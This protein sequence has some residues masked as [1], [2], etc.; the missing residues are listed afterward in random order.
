MLYSNAEAVLRGGEIVELPAIWP[1]IPPESSERVPFS[2]VKVHRDDTETQSALGGLKLLISYFALSAVI[3]AVTVFI[4][5]SHGDLSVWLN[6]IGENG[7]SG[8]R[9]LARNNMT[10]GASQF[11]P[12]D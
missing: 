8:R 9:R 5:E 4:S 2:S 11:F 6:L 10:I 3:Y 7:D 1:D 12:C